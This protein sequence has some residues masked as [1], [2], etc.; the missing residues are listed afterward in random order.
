MYWQGSRVIRSSPSKAAAHP[1]SKFQMKKTY[2]LVSKYIVATC[3]SMTSN[4]YAL[5]AS[6]ENGKICADLPTN[7]PISYKSDVNMSKDEIV[8][9]F[10]E[11]AILPDEPHKYY[12]HA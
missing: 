8:Q 7:R 1:R 12:R 11:I 2:I 3:E 4:Q 6:K 5:F 9:G 10:M